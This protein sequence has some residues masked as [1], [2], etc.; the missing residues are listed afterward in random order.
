MGPYLPGT[1]C[2]A[3]AQSA[4]G[5]NLL[6]QVQAGN[7][8]IDPALATDAAAAGLPAPTAANTV[9][10]GA[11]GQSTAAWQQAMVSALIKT[12]GQIMNNV[13]MPAGTL[14][15]K[16]ANG[17]ITYYRQPTG[18]STNL[19]VGAGGGVSVGPVGVTGSISVPMLL[20]GAGVVY[21]VMQRGQR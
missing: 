11:P 14:A 19:P 16:N 7:V 5:V 21:L 9:T 17:S 1:A 3:A 18:S 12:G 13:T 4:A 6:Q 20:L 15:V 8:N 10:V 2:D